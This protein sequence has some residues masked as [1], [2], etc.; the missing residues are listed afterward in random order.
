MC[1]DIHQHHHLQ[2]RL[3]V[4]V[5]EAERSGGRALESLHVGRLQMDLGR[6]VEWVHHTL[7]RWIPRHRLTVLVAAVTAS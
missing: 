7:L 6:E 5:E 4:P 2:Y 1:G 3:P